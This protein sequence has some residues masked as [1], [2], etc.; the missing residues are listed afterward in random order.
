MGRDAWIGWVETY[1]RRVRD[2][3]EKVPNEEDLKSLGYG[4]RGRGFL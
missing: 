1:L 3:A 2:A 4:E